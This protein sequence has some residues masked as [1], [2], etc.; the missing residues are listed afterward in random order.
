MI[1]FT[2]LCLPLCMLI[3][4]FF[5]GTECGM[6]SIN[7]A[8]LLHWARNN[9]KP[10]EILLEF[11]NN[12]QRFLATVLVGNNLFHVIVATLTGSVAKQLEMS[13][14]RE[15]VWSA[16]MA[17]A[18]LYFCEYLPKLYFRSRP[19]RRT[20][21]VAK[22]F[23]FCDRALDPL[24][25]F[26]LF[27]TKWFTPKECRDSPS[28]GEFLVTRDFLESVV[29]DRLEGASISPYETAVFRRIL[30]LQSK[31]AKDIMTPIDR[32]VKASKRMTIAQC[33]S[34]ARE[35]G[36][37]RFPVFDTD[38]TR[39]VGIINVIEELFARTNPKTSCSNRMT[40]AC[41]IN[42]NELADNLL[43]KMRA[44]KSPMLCV[45]ENHAV[46]GIVTEAT[47]LRLITNRRS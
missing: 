45:T 29:S 18:V 10:A 23:A 33:Y 17:V 4:A 25:R 35:T 38:K 32:V 34:L 36:H 12:M 41:F 8:R 5:S 20:V 2:L 42:A 27:I 28:Q 14:V 13:S 19:L 43:P 9:V 11:Q 1:I 7:P 24:T 39:C 37:F 46:I 21:R 44:K 15:S 30:K 22:I 40:P 31:C 16:T 3:T 26:V 6:N 47:V